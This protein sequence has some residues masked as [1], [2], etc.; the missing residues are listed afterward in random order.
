[1]IRSPEQL[2]T[3]IA[4]ESAALLEFRAMPETRVLLDLLDVLAEACYADLA[5]VVADQLAFKQ[6]ALA[7]LNALRD[8]IRTGGAHRSARV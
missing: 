8:M 6:G 3:K 5:T 2:R 7:Q 1:M 4:S